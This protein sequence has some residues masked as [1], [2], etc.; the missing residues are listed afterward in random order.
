MAN[1]RVIVEF[2]PAWACTT[3]WASESL[4]DAS[5]SLND[6]LLDILRDHLVENNETTE[7][8]LAKYV[9]YLNRPLNTPY[10]PIA[11]TQQQIAAFYQSLTDPP[12][13]PIDPS[14][15][16]RPLEDVIEKYRIA[17]FTIY[18]SSETQ[19]IL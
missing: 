11:A 8:D 4:V 15:I 5:K 19:E 7:L 10:F 18:E 14:D 13:E 6:A 3:I 17:I 1:I 9:V 2:V 16:E 12:H